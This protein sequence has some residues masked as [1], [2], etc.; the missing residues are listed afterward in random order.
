MSFFL[1]QYRLNVCF[2]HLKKIIFMLQ[3]KKSLKQSDLRLSRYFP[4]IKKT[5]KIGIIVFTLFL[6]FSLCSASGE[7]INISNSPNWKSTYP[8]I[9]VGPGGLVHAV[10][11]EMYSDNTGDLFYLSTDAADPQLDTPLNLSNSRNVFSETFRSCDIDVDDSGSVYAVWIEDHLINLRIFFNGEWGS[12]FEVDSS[13][14]GLDKVSI[15]VSPVGNI[16]I[17]WWSDSGI[18]FSRAQVNNVWESTERISTSGKRSKFPNIEVGD[19]VVYSCWSQKNQAL[20]IYEIAFASRNT[21]LHSS[22]SSVKLVYP[23][24]LSQS[25]P[26]VAVDVSGVPYVIWTSYV[27]GPRVVHGSEWTG[28]GFGSPQTISA[29]QLLHYA[30][31]FEQYGDLYA[32]WQVGGYEAGEAIFYNQYQNG[33]WSN[34]KSIDQSDGS[35]FSDISA[36]PDAGEIYVIWDSDGEIYITSIGATPNTNTHPVA[37]FVFSP[38]TGESPLQVFFDASLSYD[39]DGQIER[40]SWDFGDNTTGLGE[41]LDHTYNQDGTFSISLSVRD[42]QGAIDIKTKTI[43]VSF[44]NEPPVADFNFSPQS[45]DFPLQVTFDASSSVDPDGQIVR[46]SWDFGDNATGQ[47]KTVDHTYNQDG[48]YLI[49]LTV[50]DNL[51]AEDVK[52]KTIGVL[53]PNEPPVA[54]FVF[55]PLTGLFPLQVTFD[56]SSSVDPDGQIVRYSWDF[57][58]ETSGQGNSVT[59]VYNSW[60]SFPIT[61][62]IEDDRGGGDSETKTIEVLRLFLPLNIRWET[63]SDE[64]MFL[65]RYITNIKWEKNPNNN[66]IAEIVLY[67]IYRK[68]NQAEPAS[69]KYIG[70][71]EGQI[72]TYDD[73]DVE[74]KDKYNYTVTAVDS[75]G[76]ESPLDNSLSSFLDSWKRVRNRI[77]KKKK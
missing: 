69:F 38:E 27:N 72:F 24:G 6:V 61:L 33:S 40:Y 73:Y 20:D 53:P 50:E 1:P 31:L 37:E 64:S 25:H 23:N 19:Q 34:E 18:V 36:S 51:G 42:N 41:F 21:S 58:D 35:T 29:T 65:T 13:H 2:E 63:F 66:A 14:E 10:Y 60:G 4:M 12:V 70:E 62:S 30:S 43:D 54:D 57:G 56:A 9:A 45:G 28:S 26:S 17:A 68:E 7:V 48:N 5:S 47:G 77:L 74:K 75:R 67:R 44:H 16:Y 8:R 76:H 39:P 49:S 3:P 71:V 32:C 15:T 46:Y 11:V 22:W 59:H 55:S 52:T